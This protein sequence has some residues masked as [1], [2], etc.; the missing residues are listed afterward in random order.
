MPVQQR[1][2]DVANLGIAVIGGS[3]QVEGEVARVRQVQAPPFAPGQVFHPHT[4]PAPEP[5][6]LQR[7]KLR[8]RPA[9]T[10][11]PHPRGLRDGQL[12]R[13]AALLQ[14]D[15]RTG[16]YGGPLPVR[17]VS[18]HPH[19][20]TGRP[21]EPLQQLDGRRLAG[22]VGAQQCEDLAAAHGKGDSV[23]GLEPVP[24][25]TP[26]L[27]DL[28]HVFVFADVHGSSVPALGATAVRGVIARHDKC[29]RRSAHEK[30]PVPEDRGLTPERT[31][32]LELATSTLA[33][34]RS[35]N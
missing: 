8:P 9:L 26:Q 35:T 15:S 17:I 3:G 11:G 27:S 34:L 14:H 18:E 23:H 33:R 29:Q 28:N 21:G 32:R 16:P 6:Q 19:P 1:G 2:E 20:A 4:G 22:A 31:T 25:D 30:T 12:G 5:D 10:P 7:L 24:V 13:K